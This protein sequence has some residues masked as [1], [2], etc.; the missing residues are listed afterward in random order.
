MKH[1]TTKPTNEF[2]NKHIIVTGA[3]SGIGQS[4]ALYFL[5]CGAQVILAG[6]DIETMKYMTENK[7]PNATIMQVDLTSDMHIYDFKTSIVERLQSIDIIVNCA[8]VQL[9]GDV[10]KTFPQDFDYSLDINLRAVFTLIKNLSPFLNSPSSIINMSCLYGTRPCT[11]LISYAISKSGLETLTKYAAAEFANL[12]I[13]VNAITACPIETNNMRLI[14]VSEGEINIF[15]KKMIKN[16]PMGRMGRPD[17]IVRVVSFLASERS[18]KITGQIIRVDGGRA[19]TSS[20]YVHYRGLR[21]MNSRFEP[22]GVIM[23]EW[24]NNIKKGV[25]GDKKIIP[26]YD[27]EELK[28]FVDDKINE[29]NFSTRLLDAHMNVGSKYKIV[30]SNDG[31]LIKNFL[32]VNNQDVNVG[33]MKERKYDGPIQEYEKVEK[34]IKEEEEP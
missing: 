16:I 18:S 13:R 17:D 21:N 30:E 11:G 5:N 31:K 12:G 7:F 15:K 19:L 22:D 1:P 20:G 32:R 25:I 2:L 6:Q 4:V 24:F 34:V 9:D 29:S 23:G 8:G 27:Q 14:K 3:S 26:I 33:L 10:E 28:K